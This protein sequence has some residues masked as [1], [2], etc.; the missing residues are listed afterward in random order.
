MVESLKKH[1]CTN[2]QGEQISGSGHFVVNEQQEA[3]AELIEK[4]ATK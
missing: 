1:G 3:V 2:V 4:Y